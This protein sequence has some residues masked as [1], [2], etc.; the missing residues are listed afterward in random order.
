MITVVYRLRYVLGEKCRVLR[1]NT[2][3][4]Q[5]HPVQEK[6]LDKPLTTHW[7]E[8]ADSARDCVLHAAGH[9]CMHLAR[10]IRSDPNNSAQ[11]WKVHDFPAKAS[12]NNAHCKI[13]SMVLL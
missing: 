4:L 5:Y 2:H 10:I 1:I 12:Y 7:R 8:K 9:G 13:L 6:C 3:S 11:D